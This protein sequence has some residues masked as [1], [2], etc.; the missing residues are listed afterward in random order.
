[1]V[2]IKKFN[3]RSKEFIGLGSGLT[4]GALSLGVGAQVVTSAGGNVAGV[5]NLA[6]ALPTAGTVIGASFTLGLLSDL[7]REVNSKQRRRR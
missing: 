5:G 2:V 3:R 6:G 7:P 1:M 4:V